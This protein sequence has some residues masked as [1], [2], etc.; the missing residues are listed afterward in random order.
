MHIVKMSHTFSV[1]DFDVPS[2]QAHGKN[3]QN[4]WIR[5]S[6]KIMEQPGTI[7]SSY[8]GKGAVKWDLPGENSCDLDRECRWFHL[9]SRVF[10]LFNNN[11]HVLFYLDS[12]VAICSWTHNKSW[13]NVSEQSCQ[14]AYHHNN[15]Y[16]DQ[17]RIIQVEIDALQSIIVK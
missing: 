16:C 3:R 15:F 10:L 11:F 13:P 4:K 17:I 8:R 5:Y 7:W 1:G 6:V 2:S 9:I 12:A 14:I